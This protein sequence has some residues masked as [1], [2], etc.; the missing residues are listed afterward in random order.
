[1][2]YVKPIVTPQPPTVSPSP[3]TWPDTEGVVKVI[4]KSKVS[5]EVLTSVSAKIEFFEA[6]TGTSL[7]EV[8]AS[9]GTASSKPVK[10]GVKLVFTVDANGYTL[11]TRPQ[12]QAVLVNKNIV[13]VDVLLK[14]NAEPDGDCGNGI[15]DF[16]E[17]CDTTTSGCGPNAEAC[18]TACT[19]FYEDTNAECGNEIKEWGEECDSNNEQCP[20]D[21]VCTSACSCTL[22]ASV[23]SIFDS[24]TNPLFAD[25]VRLFDKESP[26]AAIQVA[27]NTSKAIFGN[28]DDERDYF[29]QAWK[30]EYATSESPFFKGTQDAEIHMSFLGDDAVNLTAVVKDSQDVLQ[31]GAIVVLKKTGFTAPVS[32]GTTNV[33]GR[34]VFAN[35]APT[36]GEEKYTLNAF[37]EASGKSG[38]KEFPLTQ[39][40]EKTVVVVGN[41]AGLLITL[42]D[43]ETQEPILGLTGV[44]IKVFSELADP[45]ED[46]ELD[47]CDNAVYAD[48]D[49]CF[50]PGLEQHTNY[51]VVAVADGFD[52]WQGVVN[53]GGDGE[54]QFVQELLIPL[55]TGGGSS[56]TAPFLDYVNGVWVNNFDEVPLKL[57]VDEI[58]P[59]DAVPIFLGETAKS[60]FE[61][62]G[63]MKLTDPTNNPC[64][65]LDYAASMDD[66]AVLYYVASSSCPLTN[67]Q[68]N[69]LGITYQGMFCTAKLVLSIDLEFARLPETFIISPSTINTFNLGAGSDVSSHANGHDLLYVIDNRNPIIPETGHFKLKDNSDSLVAELKITGQVGVLNPFDVRQGSNKDLKIYSVDDSNFVTSAVT[70]YVGFY[71]QASEHQN[72]YS[73]LW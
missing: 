8:T 7:G 36:T 3:S 54:E 63:V 35:L 22:S 69:H 25:L 13:E 42:V 56:A 29:A 26:N 5:G 16:G 4:L 71:D 6:G 20:Q 48:S 51:L 23:V 68:D 46:E 17:E 50:I 64:F 39:D 53:V 9:A 47:L 10:R 40:A 66:V 14:K 19:C 38:S 11:Y 72:D 61:T 41:E 49:S 52:E 33:Q 32:E 31:S 15:L 73:F 62:P 28:L 70:Q 24:G 55:G 59:W 44:L 65:K 21:G 34:Y 2:L 12:A 43:S 30:A 45:S 58:A 1:E 37:V 67:S 18:G 27:P 57:T 60:C